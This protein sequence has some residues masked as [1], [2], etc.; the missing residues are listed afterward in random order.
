[1]EYSCR[2]DLVTPAGTVEFNRF[3]LAARL[4]LSGVEGIAAPALRTASS[5][6]V[7]RDGDVIYPSYRRGRYPV[8]RGQ[9]VPSGASS[10]QATTSRD[11]LIRALL[12]ALDSIRGADGTLKWTPSATGAAAR[13]LTVRA[14]QE[15]QV[16][17][18]WLKEFQFGLAAGDPTVV[19]QTEQSTDSSL[20]NAAAGAETWTLGTGAAAKAWTLGT[21]GAAKDWSLGLGT[22]S[23]VATV[24]NGGDADAWPVFRIVGQ[25]GGAVRIENLTTGRALYF[26]SLSV[27]AGSYG[28][29]DTWAETAYLNSDSSL[30]LLGGLNSATSQFFPLVPGANDLRLYADSYDA[31]AMLTTLHRNSYVA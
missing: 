20:L 17:G 13:Q 6:R 28:E 7:A 27:P 3:D 22:T 29:V 1:M 18:G 23:G 25:V 2:Y 9:V 10:A 15:P 8:L 4:Q 30:S 24:T 14:W 16:S 11:T 5:S 19:A 21:S 31:T 26:D 12:A